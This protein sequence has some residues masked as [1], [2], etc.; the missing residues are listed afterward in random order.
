M[1]LG[2]GPL[3][4]RDRLVV[5]MLR[6]KRLKLVLACLDSDSCAVEL[7]LKALRIGIDL[8]Q[9]RANLIEA[10][11]AQPLAKKLNRLP[12]P[13]REDLFIELTLRF[14]RSQP[15]LMAA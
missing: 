14:F 7:G 4:L 3:P 11:G 2:S 13:C 8:G 6:L 12:I 1:Q 10:S 5:A 9:L 15:F